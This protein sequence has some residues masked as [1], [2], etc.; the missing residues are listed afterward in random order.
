MSRLRSGKLII[1]LLDAGQYHQNHVL[2]GCAASVVNFNRRDNNTVFGGLAVS[3]SNSCISMTQDLFIRLKLHKRMMV[4]F[5][6]KS[7]ILKPIN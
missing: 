7:D 1:V 6:S 3:Q 4:K 2:N 5:D